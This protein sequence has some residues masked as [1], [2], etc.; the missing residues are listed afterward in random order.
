MSTWR[1]GMAEALS[2]RLVEFA[3][4]VLKLVEALPHS[5]AARH[6]GDQL[7]RSATSPG[8]NYE[9][10]RAAESKADFVH[11]YHIAL[12]ELRESLYWLRLVTRAGYVT[13]KSL[14]R[15]VGECQELV[16]VFSKSLATAKKSLPASGSEDM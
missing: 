2:E 12:K 16:L 15:L 9:E 5:K 13:A 1:D 10:A 4:R 11:K 14:N 3:V 6:C 8:A 7:L